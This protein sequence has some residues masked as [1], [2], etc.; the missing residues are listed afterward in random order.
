M[1]EV[2]LCDRLR[3]TGRYFPA[4][5][6]LSLRC[7]GWSPEWAERILSWPHT[8]FNV[9]SHIFIAWVT[10]HIPDKGQVMVRYFGLYANAHRGKVKKASQSPT[11]L[12]IVEDSPDSD[13]SSRTGEAQPENAF[14]GSPH[15]RRSPGRLFF[16]IG[17]SLEGALCAI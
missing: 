10:S 15:G 1:M 17:P 8:G 2:R 5:I 16:V 3:Q 14:P 4:A 11:T 12:R 9:H 13:A 6:T 7:D